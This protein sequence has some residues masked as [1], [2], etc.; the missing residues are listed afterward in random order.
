M[1]LPTYVRAWRNRLP[2]LPRKL[3][4][5]RNLALSA[6]LALAALALLE[7]P[8]LSAFGAFRRIEGAYLLTPSRLVCQ[9]GNSRNM[10]FLTEGDSWITMGSVTKFDS[11]SKPLNIDKYQAVLHY[12]L[13]KEGIVTVLLPAMDEDGKVPAAVWGGPEEAVSATLEVELEGIEAAFGNDSVPGLETFT[14]QAERREDGW[15]LFRFTP[16]SGHRAGQSCA[17]EMF[18]WW[19]FTPGGR[20]E[21]NYR[22]TLWDAQGREAASQ[23]GILP[24]DQTLF[25]W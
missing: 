24:P 13:P 17:M 23:S 20:L 3:R 14:A 15:F 12:V 11:G 9:A 22:L 19:L 10:V 7:W 1:K 5:I 18:P 21:Q 2:K 4:I 16:H 8:S 25:E 6:A